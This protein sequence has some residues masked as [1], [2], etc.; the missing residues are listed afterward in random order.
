MLGTFVGVASSSYP[1]SVLPSFVESLIGLAKFF[2]L[3]FFPLFLIFFLNFPEQSPL[4]LR[5]PRLESW[6]YLP[7][8]LFVLPTW[9]AGGSLARRVG[10]LVS[11]QVVARAW[12]RNLADGDYGSLRGSG[13][14]LPSH[15]LS[16]RQS[17][18]LANAMRV[19][20]AGSRHRILRAFPVGDRS[21]FWFAKAGGLAT[22]FKL[23]SRLCA[24]YTADLSA[25]V[26]LC[27]YQTQGYS[28]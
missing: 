17:P 9:L 26:R 20:M 10:G 6:L 15:Q 24:L 23:D 25:L 2:A 4:L 22:N 5:F 8:C 28:H 18:K 12:R 11:L 16:R 21:H 3:W 7:L 14:D 13:L 19:A 27:H 1:Y